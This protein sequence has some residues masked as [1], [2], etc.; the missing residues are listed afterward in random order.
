MTDY[1]ETRDGLQLTA[2]ATG[3]RCQTG[4]QQ[5]FTFIEI[6]I[7]I[8][9]VGIL[10]ATIL[11]N[12]QDGVRKSRRAD[13]RAALAEMASRQEQ[14]FGQNNTYTTVVDTGGNGLGMGKTTSAKGYYDLTIAAGA[15]G[16]ISRCYILTATASGEQVSDEPCNKL[17]LDSIGRRTG[18]TKAGSDNSDVCW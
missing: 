7:V 12:Y 3:G 14:F 1:I 4:R 11:P 9:I 8:V 6:L 2:P 10:A 16:D 5:G 15:C 18:L 13:G 17:T